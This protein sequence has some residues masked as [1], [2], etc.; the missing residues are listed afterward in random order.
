MLIRSR[1]HQVS[2][3]H[4]PTWRH[5]HEFGESEGDPIMGSP[6]K[7]IELRSFLGLV[8]YYRKFVEGYSRRVIPLTEIL[9]KGVSWKWIDGCQAVFDNLKQAM[10]GD[11]VL[12]LLDITKPFEV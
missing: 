11:P 8:N 7:V 5:P 9:K 2:W 10:S 6:T 12:A 3:E 1:A 4:Y